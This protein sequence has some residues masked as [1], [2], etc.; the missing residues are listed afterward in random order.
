MPLLRNILTIL[1]GLPT[2]PGTCCLPLNI[3]FSVPV[4]QFMLK[5]YQ[6]MYNT[7]DCLI[8]LEKI[9]KKLQLQFLVV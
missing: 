1:V 5:I 7:Y 3:T 2:I 8:F 9:K 4:I 6:Y